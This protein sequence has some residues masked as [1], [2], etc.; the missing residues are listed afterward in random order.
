[1]L[2]QL[3]SKYFSRMYDI[4]IRRSI[5]TSFIYSWW[6]EQMWITKY[7]IAVHN[8]FC[9]LKKP[10]VATD[11]LRSLYIQDEKIDKGKNRVYG[12]FW[13]LLWWSGI[14]LCI[15]METLSWVSYVSHLQGNMFR[16]TDI[17]FLH[18]V[19]FVIQLL[20]T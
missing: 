8:S 4:N 17:F 2:H 14:P 7:S 5:C 10:G 12:Y 9:I 20:S 11:K 19:R 18:S 16:C 3:S 15:E 1:M 6:Y 13:L